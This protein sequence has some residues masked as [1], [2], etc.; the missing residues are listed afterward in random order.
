M[1]MKVKVCGLRNRENIREVV[2]C[3]PDFLGFIFYPSS[4]RYVGENMD[5]RLLRSIPPYIYKVGVFVNEQIDTMISLVTRYSLDFV[6]LHGNEEPAVLATLKSKR[7]GTIKSF[8]VSENFDFHTVEPFLPLSD[9]FLF[10]TQSEW[11]GGSGIKFNWSIMEK[12]NLTKPFFL[13]GGISFEDIANIT[14]LRN[15]L[16]YG[17]DIN[18]R[19]ET[20]Q[21]LKDVFMVGEFIKSLKN[22]NQ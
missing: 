6:Q 5:P 7:I 4:P 3:K 2:A 18:S 21:G 1:S 20:S 19:F 14:A 22:R 17:V 13:S 11:Y 9:F 16:Y 8:Q 15:P 12:Y 10:D